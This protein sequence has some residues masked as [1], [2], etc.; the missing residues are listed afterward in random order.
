M[1]QDYREGLYDLLG[2]GGI[3][4]NNSMTC[5]SSEI[6]NIKHICVTN[7][8]ELNKHSDWMNV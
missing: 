1:A 8:K 3:W 6:K 7:Y 5:H 2:N 4:A